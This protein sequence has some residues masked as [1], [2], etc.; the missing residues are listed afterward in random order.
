MQRKPYIHRWTGIRQVAATCMIGQW[1]IT[2]P[3][4]WAQLLVVAQSH[5]SHHLV[6]KSQSFYLVTTAN[7]TIIQLPTGHV[8]CQTSTSE[9]KDETGWKIVHKA[10]LCGIE[11]R[12]RIL[13]WLLRLHHDSR[14]IHVI[15]HSRQHPHSSPQ[16]TTQSQGTAIA[17]ELSAA[18]RFFY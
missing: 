14:R 1:L 2:C 5:P 18:D 9:K 13:L 17:Q 15:L 16:V 6:A 8:G 7:A 3:R 4:H 11:W 12:R 10:E